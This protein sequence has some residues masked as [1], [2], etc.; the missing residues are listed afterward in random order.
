M[1]ALVPLP[2]SRHIGIFCTAGIGVVALLLLGG[3][4]LLCPVSAHSS[5]LWLPGSPAVTTPMVER[6]ASVPG[7]AKGRFLVASR[8]L[9]EAN[10]V[11]T[12]VL[13][14]DYN[15]RGARGLIIN[16]PSELR[17]AKVFPELAGLQQREDTVYMGGPVEPQRLM[18]LIRTTS[19][20][21]EAQ[22]VMAD[23][24]VSTSR[25][26][27]E[28]L[29]DTLDTARRFRAYAGYAGWGPGQL[30][31]EVSQGAWHIVPAE[32]DTV[33][34]TAPA[35]IWPAMIQKSSIRWLSF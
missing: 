26:V 32:A 2:P 5:T 11:E 1:I 16:R 30:E 17:L 8:T 3:V 14:V 4:Q 23:I 24:Y 18:L 7:L 29:V 22:Q 33:F 10:F 31:R 28:H 19:A 13:L 34:D 25:K 27:L 12:V 15:Q 35:D 9:R 20:P 21:A 6:W